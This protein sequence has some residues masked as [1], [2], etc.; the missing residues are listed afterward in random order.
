MAIF[1]DKSNPDVYQSLLEVSKRAGMAAQAAGLQPLLVEL[2]KMRASQINGCAYCLRLH[3]RLALGLGETSDRL[4]VLS[5]WRETDYFT[6][7]ERAALAITEEVTLVA[8]VMAG[9]RS[10]EGEHPE[11][12]DA[13][14]AAIRWV[15]ITINSFNR[16]SILSHHPVDPDEG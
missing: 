15:A 7:A 16:V 14:A 10:P 3:S 5:T 8:D 12:T 11:L 6:E 9:R 4:A 2:V 1:L 13:Q